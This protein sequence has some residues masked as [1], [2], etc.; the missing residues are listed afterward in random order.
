LLWAGLNYLREGGGGRIV[1]FQP[2]YGILEV[3]KIQT[4][5]HG[6][7]L[8]FLYSSAL[9]YDDGITLDGH[10]ANYLPGPQVYVLSR[11]GYLA[12][13]INEHLIG[14]LG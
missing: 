8:F 11:A 14:Q 2:L 1:P 13:G 5:G 10:H 4:V 9:E 7:R 6:G 3:R 12:G